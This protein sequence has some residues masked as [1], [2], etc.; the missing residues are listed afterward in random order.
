M[1]YRNC[2]HLKVASRCRFQMY[3]TLE[4]LGGLLKTQVPGVYFVSHPVGLE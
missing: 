2:E 1:V 4:F 3:H